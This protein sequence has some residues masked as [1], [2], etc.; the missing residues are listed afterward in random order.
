[1]DAYRLN[2]TSN[3][4]IYSDF[5]CGSGLEDV[6]KLTLLRGKNDCGNL[7]KRRMTNIPNENSHP[8]IK[9]KDFHVLKSNED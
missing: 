1:M 2:F 4:G 3:Y 9:L 5:Y 7:L 8:M 6:L